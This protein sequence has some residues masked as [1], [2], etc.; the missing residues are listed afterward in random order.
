MNRKIILIC[1]IIVLLFL[2]FFICLYYNSCNYEDLIVDEETWNRII[3]ERTISD[4][5]LITSI[6]FNDY[7]LLY[8]NINCTYYYSLIE[9]AS[10]KYNPN[11]RYKTNKKDLKLVINKKIN[12][13]SIANNDCINVML[14]NDTEFSI[15][16][17]RCTTLP[18]LNINSSDIDKISNENDV[19]MNLY[20]FDNRKSTAKRVTK[21]AGKMHIRGAITKIFPKK[22]YKL[23]LKTESLGNNT[24][25]NHL[26][27]L[28]MRK[29]DDWI[30]YAAYNDQ[31]KIRNVFATNLWYESCAKNN[32]FGISNGNEFKF[33]E[34]FLNNEYWGLYALGYRIDEKQLNIDN[35]SE[36]MFKKIQYD[37]SEINILDKKEFDTSNYELVNNVKDEK[38]AWTSLKNYYISLLE[39]K[40]INELYNISDIN[41]LIDY[42][43]FEEIIQGNDNPKEM[44]L[45]NVFVTIKNFNNKN[46]I[47]YT[48]WDYDMCLG[49]IYNSNAKNFTLPYYVKIDENID[50]RFNAIGSLK[51]LN[52]TKINDLVKNRYKELRNTYWSEEHLEDLI[53]TYSKQIYDSGAFNRDNNKWNDASFNE[54]NIKLTEF[55]EYV[56]DRLKY[57][58][59]F[60]NSNF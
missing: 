12:D 51:K 48:P 37:E 54:E 19:D 18:L 31:E 40:D 39:S 4:T 52:D 6:K 60:I 29:D 11:V 33:V 27:L 23:S 57:T 20:L 56:F 17:L 43:L 25:S 44:Y 10:N 55:K 2:T 7:E 49:N 14:Y 24:R 38:K 21:S 16:A 46:V 35:D 13:Q 34:L 50:F 1:I 15:Y 59:E 26:S 41:N 47:L 42:Y 36:Y 8:D 32:M 22:G 30:L 3:S 45:K 58:D 5:N 28:G 9:S 53:S